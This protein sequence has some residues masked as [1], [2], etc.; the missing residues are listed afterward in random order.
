MSMSKVTCDSEYGTVRV[1][2]EISTNHMVLSTSAELSNFIFC[3]K[4][5]CWGKGVC[6]PPDVHDAH[7]Y[8]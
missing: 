1:S 6:S 7:A 2:G 4:I 3:F 5:I 8:P